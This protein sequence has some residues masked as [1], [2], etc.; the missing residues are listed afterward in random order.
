M[1]EEAPVLAGWDALE[2][3]CADVNAVLGEVLSLDWA[4]PESA[5]EDMASLPAA[6]RAFDRWP[7]LCLKAQDV[8]RENGGRLQPRLLMSRDGYNLVACGGR[9]LA[10]P[11]GLG[12]LDLDAVDATR[13]EGVLA[14]DDLAQALA[15][16]ERSLVK[17]AAP[18]RLIASEEGINIV[19]FAGRY[20]AIPQ[21]LGPMDLVS[22][23]V[24]VLPG[25][26]T[27]S[28]LESLRAAL[29]HDRKR[30]T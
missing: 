4:R 27:A 20:L 6:V 2:S 25:V 28:S 14:G 18:P 21:A 11:H 5:V 30:Q 7:D 1:A 19:S 23:D 9:V 3:G 22:Q 13:L 8:V 24:S 29:I 15:Q 17:D 26:I 16:L 12:P 10:I